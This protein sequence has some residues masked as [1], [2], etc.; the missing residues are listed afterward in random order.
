M[1]IDEIVR[2]NLMN[3][4]NADAHDDSRRR[5]RRRSRAGGFVRSRKVQCV[6]KFCVMVTHRRRSLM[7]T[8]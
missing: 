1:Y 8:Q 6:S 3:I 2:T 7:I 5:Y 4:S